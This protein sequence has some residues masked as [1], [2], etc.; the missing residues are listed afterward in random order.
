VEKILGIIK[1]LG[2]NGT[3]VAIVEHR[4]GC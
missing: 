2:G 3:A 4:M 1:E